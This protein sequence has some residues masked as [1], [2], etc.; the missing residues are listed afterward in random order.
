MFKHS[1]KWLTALLIFTLA[2]LPFATTATTATAAGPNQGTATNYAALGDSIA[3][4][5]GGTNYAGYVNY[6]HSYLQTIHGTV[7]KTNVSIPGIT[8]TDL[9]TQLNTNT[10]ARSAVKN[11]NVLTISIGGN[12]LLRCASDN[13]NTL[14]TVC[15]ENGVTAFQNDWPLI[16]KE[17]RSDLGSTAKLYMLT[18]YNPYL[19]SD[20]NY[21][22]AD[23]YITRINA[24]I[25]NSTT[26]TTYNY[27]VADA[28]THFQGQLSDG[29][30][31]T[32]V[33]THFTEPTRDPHP[34]DAGYKELSRLHEVIYP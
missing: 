29:T 14:D 21:T 2:F 9:L 13:Y 4:G 19:P 5:V 25:Q 1:N 16:L 6:F 22:L 3:Y 12:N 23:S 30:Y 15:A 18:I 10:T 26:M 33:W 27:K 32:A 17:I 11:A 24:I 20:P 34:T 7:N 28:Y 31:K 8:T